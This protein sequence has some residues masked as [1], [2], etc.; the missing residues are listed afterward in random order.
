MT[1]HS[2]KINL[3]YKMQRAKKPKTVSHMSLK[4]KKKSKR[5]GK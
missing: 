1:S 3:P 4:K 2:S 5:K